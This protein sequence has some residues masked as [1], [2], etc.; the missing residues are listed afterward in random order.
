MNKALTDK[1]DFIFNKIQFIATCH[2]LRAKFTPV[3]DPQVY[4]IRLLVKSRW[5]FVL[6]N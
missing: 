3:P 4:K 5:R 2:N 1:H 6:F